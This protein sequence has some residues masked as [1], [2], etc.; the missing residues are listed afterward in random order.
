MA[1]TINT[2][3]GGSINIVTGAGTSERWFEP[4]YTNE[5][6]SSDGSTLNNIIFG[7]Y[8]P[9]NLPSGN[10]ALPTVYRASG[11]TYDATSLFMGNYDDSTE[12]DKI[13]KMEFNDSTTGEVSLTIYRKYTP[14]HWEDANGN[15]INGSWGAWSDRNLYWSDSSNAYEY[16]MVN[17]KNNGGT[18]YPDSGKD[19]AIIVTY[20]YED[21]GSSSSYGVIVRTWNNTNSCLIIYFNYQTRKSPTYVGDFLHPLKK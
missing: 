7:P 14:G 9:E 12:S 20:P 6:V 4:Q 16:A 17:V 5:W 13:V 15:W 10:Y 2:L 21:N 8:G 11:N 1:I 19:N 18:V 3:I